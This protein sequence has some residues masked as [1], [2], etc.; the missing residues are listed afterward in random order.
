MLS[1][2]I[3]DRVQANGIELVY[4]SFGRPE[5]PPLLLV[6][7][8]GTQRLAWAEPFCEQLAAQGF[9]VI[10]FDNRDIGESTHLHEL[11]SPNPVAIAVRRR[12]PAYGLDA[13]AD[14]TIALIEALALDRVHLV[15]ASMGGFIAQLVAIRAPERIRSLTLFMTSTG[16]RRVGRP[17][18]KLVST[19]LRRKPATDR[20]SAIE[21]S[22]DMFRLI[23]SPAYPFNEDQIRELAGVSY[24]RG[25][26]PAGGQRQLAAIVAQADR[27]RELRRL[28][29]PTV[30]IHGFSDPLVA[31][32]GG[33]AIARAVPGS[34]FVGF[35]GMG[36]DMP[37]ALW[38]DFISEIV[39]VAARSS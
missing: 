4:D 8:L 34:R 36:H 11:P 22:V 32:S 28:Q 15:G 27:T 21:A 17:S 10:R 37:A 33:L 5:D 39:G 19:V 9:R 25:Y 6:M 16:S 20:A 30:V 38:P 26:D 35:H 3:T 31:P 13:M 18:A 12:R 23:R 24:D 2:M 14:D 1:G 7:G 29:M